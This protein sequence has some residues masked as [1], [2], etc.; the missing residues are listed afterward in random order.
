MEPEYV[1]DAF[2]Q[3][4]AQLA[5]MVTHWA[6]EWQIGYQ[7]Q[8]LALLRVAAQRQDYSLGDALSREEGGSR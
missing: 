6:T 3:A 4:E 5:E 8:A 7:E 2:W 1:S